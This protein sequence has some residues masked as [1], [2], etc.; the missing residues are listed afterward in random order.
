MFLETVKAATRDEGFL[1]LQSPEAI[2]G[3]STAT[4]ILMWAAVNVSLVQ[5]CA[6]VLIMKLKHFLKQQP[7]TKSL[8]EK[9]V[10]T[11]YHQLWNSLTANAQASV[12]L[13]YSSNFM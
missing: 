13:Y 6:E 12:F 5:H 10:S 3:Y 8:R 2:T 11:V 1:R 9:Y 4:T 7:V